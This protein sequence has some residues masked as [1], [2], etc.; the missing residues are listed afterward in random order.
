N[1]EQR[2]LPPA[3]SDLPDVQRPERT[4]GLRMAQPRGWRP[5]SVVGRPFSEQRELLLERQVQLHP[6]LY[7]KIPRKSTG[8]R[9]HPRGTVGSHDPSGGQRQTPPRAL[10]FLRGGETTRGERLAFERYA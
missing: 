7:P 2:S 5:F 4:H 6:S 3:H 8:G 9:D 10:P 1:A